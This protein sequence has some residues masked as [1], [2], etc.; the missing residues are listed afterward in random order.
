VHPRLSLTPRRRCQVPAAAGIASKLEVLFDGLAPVGCRARRSPTLVGHPRHT[1]FAN[2]F[3]VSVSEATMRPNPRSSSPPC[4]VARAGCG[5]HIKIGVEPQTPPIFVSGRGR[6]LTT[7]RVCAGALRPG[8]GDR[9][10][11]LRRGAAEARAHR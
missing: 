1:G 8:G 3:G 9:A 7:G 6:R 5:A 2:V 10:V 4:A 11:S